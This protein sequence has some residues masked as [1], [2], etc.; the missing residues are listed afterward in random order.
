MQ[1]KILLKLRRLSSK[2][3]VTAGVSVLLVVVI[4]VV[5]L[6]S[7]TK[8]QRSVSAYCKVHKEQ[9]ALL[10][11]AGGDKYIYSSAVFP[12]ASSNNA[13]DFVPAFRELEKVAP[14][15]IEPQVKAIGDIFQKMSDEP[16]QVLSLAMNGLPAEKAVTNWTQQNCGD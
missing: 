9:A 4:V 15:E 6:S 14:N 10:G 7:A 16:T 2:Q 1:H 11:H 13:A 3:Q 12:G 5:F 8:P